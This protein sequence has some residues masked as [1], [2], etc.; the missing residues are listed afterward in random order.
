MI[1]CH[2]CKPEEMHA[3]IIDQYTTINHHW[4]LIHGMIIL[5]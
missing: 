4:I 2:D 5:K 1:F 3:D